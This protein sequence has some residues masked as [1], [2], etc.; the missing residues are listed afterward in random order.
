M[1]RH[2]RR[3]PLLPT[4]WLD[5]TPDIARLFALVPANW[6]PPLRVKVSGGLRHATVAARFRTPAGHV[7]TARVRLDEAAQDLATVSAAARPEPR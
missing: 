6:T 4:V 1:A 3:R 7:S 5:W 2:R